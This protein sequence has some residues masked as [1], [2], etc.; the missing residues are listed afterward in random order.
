M[1]RTAALGLCVARAKSKAPF[2]VLR[3]HS[4]V[5]GRNV[6]AGILLGCIIVEVKTLVVSR[7]QT[8]VW[9]NAHKE[10]ADHKW[11]QNVWVFMNAWCGWF[12]EVF[13]GAAHK[14]VNRAK[15]AIYTKRY[16]IIVQ[17]AHHL[18]QRAIDSRDSMIIYTENAFWI[19]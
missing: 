7:D 8:V 4:P 17:R 14:Y 3:R 16:S 6:V 5:G 18:I 9:H 1:N 13:V 10:S 15:H 12:Q 2:V 19:R 11:S